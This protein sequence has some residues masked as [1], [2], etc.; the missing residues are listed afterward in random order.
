MLNIIAMPWTQIS[1]FCGIGNI[2]TKGK[3]YCTET[4]KIILTIVIYIRGHCT[5]THPQKLH[6]G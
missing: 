4:H 1:I 6:Q 2:G 3:D 5:Y